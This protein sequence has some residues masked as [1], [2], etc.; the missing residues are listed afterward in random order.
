MVNEPI[1]LVFVSDLYFSP[2]IESAAEGVGFRVQ[3][4]ETASQI[5]PGDL[6]VSDEP[7]GE[8][9]VGQAGRLIE[10]VTAWQPALMIFDL[11]N[12]EVPWERWIPVLKTSAATRRIPILAFGSHMDVGTMGR[13]KVVG[14]DVVLARSAFVSDLPNLIRKYARIPD[15]DAIAEG[16]AGELSELAREGIRLFNAGEYFEAHEVLEHA[17]NEDASAAK[18][19]YRAILQVAVAYLQIERGNYRGAVKMFLR[20]RQWFAPLPEV[21]RGVDVMGLQEAARAVEE[22][23][24][25]LGEERLGELDRGLFQPVRFI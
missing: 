18:E 25:A 14:A 22:R 11:N 15:R 23:V 8:H 19:L 7:L 21:C 3:L 20:M 10:Q 17:W 9:L 1:L 16:C 5:A 13:A 12:G 4:I 2:R 24:L 6:T